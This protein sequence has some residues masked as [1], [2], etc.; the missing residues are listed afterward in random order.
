MSY[1]FMRI[2]VFF[3]LPVTTEEHRRSYRK[4]RKLLEQEGFVMMQESVYCKITLNA[5]MTDLVKNKLNKLGFT[6][7][8]GFRL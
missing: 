8:I 6:D 3:D 4:F 1:R 7:M 5:T 2:M